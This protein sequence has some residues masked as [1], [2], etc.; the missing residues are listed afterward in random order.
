[1]EKRHRIAKFFEILVIIFCSVV[2]CYFMVDAG[3]KFSSRVT[4][5][6]IKIRYSDGAEKILPCVS[7]CPIP[8]KT[9]RTLTS[10]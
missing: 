10:T 9:K 7:V 8:G 6:G 1:M 4:N 3:I 2:F 5:S